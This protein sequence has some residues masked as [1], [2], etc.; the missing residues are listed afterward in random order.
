[1][2]IR[3]QSI[4]QA[5]QKCLPVELE[6]LVDA[7]MLIRQSRFRSARRGM[8]G[9][10]VD[11]RVCRICALDKREWDHISFCRGQGSLPMAKD[12][13]HRTV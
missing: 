2:A 8:T 10:R 1:M 12:I 6:L 5:G 4:A 3:P 7:Y 13:R 11:W 9:Y